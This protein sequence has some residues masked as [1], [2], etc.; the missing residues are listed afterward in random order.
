MG[1]IPFLVSVCFFLLVILNSVAFL[2]IKGRLIYFRKL[3]TLKTQRRK[4]KSCSMISPVEQYGPEH[5]RWPIS[6][7]SEIFCI[8]LPM[9][10]LI[11]PHL[12]VLC[13]GWEVLWCWEMLSVFNLP[14][15]VGYVGCSIVTITLWWMPLKV[16]FGTHLLSFLKTEA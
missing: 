16:Q 10:L 12:L 4:K 13:T 6:F 8:S 9:S 5:M 14:P 2:V 1:P 15:A 11:L 3:I 7:H